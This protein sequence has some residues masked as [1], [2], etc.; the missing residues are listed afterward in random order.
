[1]LQ[2]LNL[3]VDEDQKLMTLEKVKILVILRLRSWLERFLQTPGS[4]AKQFGSCEPGD[5]DRDRDA[6]RR[7]RDNA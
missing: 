2:S 5:D 7:F 6:G 4:P 1:M 3:V